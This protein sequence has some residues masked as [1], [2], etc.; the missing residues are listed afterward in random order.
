MNEQPQLGF[1]FKND[2]VFD[3]YM[4]DKGFPHWGSPEAAGFDIKAYTGKDVYLDRFQREL[5]DTG[6]Y[7][8]IPK[9]Y[10]LQVRPRSGLAYKH[11]I[12]VLNSPGTIDSDYKGEVKVLLINLSGSQFVIEHGMKIAQ[13]VMAPVIRPEQYHSFT[14]GIS[15]RG[16][17]GFGSTGI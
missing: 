12:T 7:F 10:E 8:E 1:K 13:I 11:G 15:L 3:M 9:G 5:I 4:N 16:E 17:G 6:V 14:V 2:D